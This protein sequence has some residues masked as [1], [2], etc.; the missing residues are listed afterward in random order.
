[1]TE[2]ININETIYYAKKSIEDDLCTEFNV[3]IEFLSNILQQTEA[4]IAGGYILSHISKGWT[5]SDIDVYVNLRNV[6]TL[7]QFFRSI[8]Y[9][10]SFIHTAPPYDQSFFRKNNIIQ[11][12]RMYHNQ[13]GYI[14]LDIIVILDDKTVESVV[15]NFDLT[16]CEVWYDGK[17]IKGSNL[18]DA[19]MKKGKLR[20]EYNK[21]LFENFNNFIIERLKKYTYRGYKITYD[22]HSVE[23]LTINFNMNKRVMIS[24]EDWFVSELYNS[25]M[26]YSVDDIDPLLQTFWY[27]KHPLREKTY[28]E[29]NKFISVR[30]GHR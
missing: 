22:C 13:F 27:I 29:I 1:M 10:I 14:S 6:V 17:D 15:T 3:R 7:I 4:V 9:R 21:A 25:F 2:D 12:I 18:K 5:S 24:E 28:K 16:F 26:S 30:F 11:R 8:N 19:I 23:E 20:V